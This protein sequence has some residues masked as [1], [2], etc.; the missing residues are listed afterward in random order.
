MKGTLHTVKGNSA[1]MGLTPMQ[2]LAHAL[3]DLC[4]LLARDGELRT[5]QAAALLVSGGS[6]LVE[7]VAVGR[8]GR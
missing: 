4:G 1:M 6:L 8:E 3:E 5:E 7:Q 2:E